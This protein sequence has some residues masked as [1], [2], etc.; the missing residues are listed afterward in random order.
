M[1]LQQLH[2]MMEVFQCG[3]INKASQ[4]LF[5]SQSAISDA[6]RELERE[7]GITVF[8]RSNRGVQLTDAGADFIAQVQPILEQEK[9]I[10]KIYGEKSG[11]ERMRLSIASQRY[12]FCAKAF[13]RLLEETSVEQPVKLAIREMDMERV[14]EEVQTGKSEI[15]V[16]FISDRTESFI[17][18]ILDKAMLEFTDFKSF[19]PQV[20]LRKDHPLHHKSSLSLS[21]LRPYPYVLF[22]QKKQG[23]VYFAEEAVY[24]ETDNFSRVVVINDRATAYNIIANTDGFSIGSGILPE[25]YCDSR[26]IS[27]PIAEETKSMHLGWIHSKERPLHPQAKHYIQILQQVLEE[28]P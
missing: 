10:R 5:V 20:F 19:H 26:I 23:S 27:I 17:R 6:I 13:V 2:Y 28:E 7:L 25:G 9:R 11:Q 18:R 21:E 24:T 14:I 12:P 8:R 4:S 16:I 15:G 22:E 3:S 1:T